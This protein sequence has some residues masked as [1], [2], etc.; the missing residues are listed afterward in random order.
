LKTFKNLWHDFISFENFYLA[1]R[2]AKKGKRYKQSA[3]EFNAFQE[4]NLLQLISELK[5]GAY[6]PGEYRIF[7]IFDPKERDIC[8]APYR[9]RVVHHA[10]MNIL[11]P[12]WEPSFYHHSYACRVG[13]GMHRALDT[14]Q[15]YMK[16][17]SYVLKCDIEKYFPSIDHDILLGIISRKI[18]DKR[19]LQVIELIISSSPQLSTHAGSAVLGTIFASQRRA[20]LPIGNLPSQFFANLYLNELDIVVKQQLCQKYYIRFMDDFLLFGNSKE[21]LVQLRK[22]IVRCVDDL[23]LRLHPK[24]QEIF[25]LKNGIP[26][27]GMLIKRDYRR[28]RR[29]N[30]QR[31][32]KRMRRKQNEYS[33]NIITQTDLRQSLMAWLGYAAKANSQSLRNKLI[34]QF[35]FT[36]ERHAA[37]G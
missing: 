9:D 25:P 24:K 6:R 22:E 7:K 21:R 35:V 33:V 34:P 29:V 1:A 13:K 18:N 36:K 5:E 28:I 30:L 2:K 37:K 10:L 14:V 15:S 12:L 32:T 8:A 3:L 27:L 23:R 11:E 16:R 26:F 31:F 20:G 19:L 4:E 17:N